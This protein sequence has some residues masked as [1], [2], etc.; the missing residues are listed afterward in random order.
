MRPSSITKTQALTVST[1]TFILSNDPS[2]AYDISNLSGLSTTLQ[3]P[4][5][6]AGTVFYEWSNTN[7]TNNADW[8]AVNTTLYPNATAALV[9]SG[10]VTLNV[11]G[12]HVAFLRLRVTL[13]AG[14]GSYTAYTL[15]K[16]F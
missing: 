10:S 13:S 16:D 3:C 8:K 5:S 1:Q 11:H 12:I 2:G 4:A 9:A 6:A 7:S 14:A 15:G